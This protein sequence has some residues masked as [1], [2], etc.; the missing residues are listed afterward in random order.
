MLLSNVEVTSDNIYNVYT[1]K[2]VNIEN[3]GKKLLQK[4]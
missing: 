3:C 2:L 1:Y 4:V